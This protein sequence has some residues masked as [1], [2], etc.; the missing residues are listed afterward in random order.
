MNT[1]DKTIYGGM[2]AENE[3]NPQ[4]KNEQAN[5]E[6]PWKFVGMGA[7]TGILMG[8]GALYATESMASENQDLKPIEPATEDHQ[9]NGDMSV[10]K[11][12]PN[13][14]FEHAFAE[15]RAQVGPGGVFY[16]HGG[17]YNTFTKAEWD[18]MSDADKKAFAAKIQPEYE[19]HRINTA[20]ITKEH[21]QVHIDK[22]EVNEYHVSTTEEKDDDVHVVGHLGTDNYSF[23]DNNISVDRY[24]IDGHEAAVMNFN[25]EDVHN[26]A[27]EDKNND[28]KVNDGELKDITTNEVLDSNFNPM[29]SSDNLMADTADSCS[30]DDSTPAL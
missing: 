13:D 9:T 4:V 25:K 23:G 26:I 30:A 18:A 17:I 20:H 15:A 29:H 3:E 8:A 16:W 11:V 5:K 24:V 7:A 22:M 21:P 2:P 28:H 14:S 19:V 1:N 12:N 6:V 10:A 27:W